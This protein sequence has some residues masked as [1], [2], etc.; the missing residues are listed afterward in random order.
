MIRFD[1]ALDSRDL[2]L[3]A[4]KMFRNIIQV[5]CVEMKINSLGVINKI[6]F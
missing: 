3:P 4:I 5:Y 6:V 2:P 1:D